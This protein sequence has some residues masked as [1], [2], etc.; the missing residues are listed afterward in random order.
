MQNQNLEKGKKLNKKE[1]RSI[2]GG[3]RQCIDP[4]TNQCRVFGLGCAEP[5]CR[6]ILEL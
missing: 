5:Q 6:P 3:L 2:T 4:A 1:L